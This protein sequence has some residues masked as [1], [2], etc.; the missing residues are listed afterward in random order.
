MSSKNRVA[1]VGVGYSTTGRRT[2]LTSRQLAV[3]AAI[4]AMRDAGMT[5]KDIDGSTMLWGVAGAAPPGLDVAESMDIASMLGIGPLNFWNS[6]AGPAYIGPAVQ[7]VA[8]IKSGLCHTVLSMRVIRQRLTGAEILAE[9]T[10]AKPTYASDD[11][12]FVEP[13]GSVSPM[14]AIAA[15]PAQRYM[16]LY[17][18]TEEHFGRHVVAQ[19]QWASH[20]PDAI[21][22]T[23]LTLDDYFAS[24]YIAK[25]VRLLDCDYPVD[26]ASAIIYTTEERARDFAKKPIFAESTALSSVKYQTFENLDDIIENSPDHCARTLWSRTDLKPKDVDCVQLYDGFTII[27]F[28]WLEALGFCGRGEAGHFIAEGRTAMGG[29]LPLNTD[30]GACNVGRR[31]G[32]NFCIE[33]IRQ[34]RGGESGV[35]QVPDAKVALW[36]NAVGSF[37]GAMLMTA[38]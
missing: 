31:H 18:A 33:S 10:D 38:D 32:A 25:P 6:G 2:G 3:Q 27:V 26:S 17:G 15:M 5:P 24:R 9:D 4:A 22:Q 35:R 19:R 16:D 34:L 21:F 28:Q 37:S 20:N 36:A 11:R 23:P 13:F 7:A 12:Q 14:Q 1:A 8:A 29:S 30:G